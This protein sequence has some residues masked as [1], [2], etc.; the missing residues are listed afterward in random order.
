M[1]EELV[2][3]AARTY[4]GTPWKHQA[5]VKG[6]GVDCIGL[7]V[8]AFREAG[9]SIADVRDYGRCPNPRRFLHHLGAQFDRISGG[10]T[11]S[12][13]PEAWTF[14]RQGDLL[15]FV[16]ADGMPQHVGIA[17]DNG[18]IHTY[19][20]AGFVA[21]HALDGEWRARVHSVWRIK[22]WRRS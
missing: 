13:D 12:A 1:S 20:T 9:Y 21:E 19:Q 8:G 7:L 11:E 4:L 10:D 17:T 16:F 2:I 3:Q 18:V 22:P 6:I 5:R 14:A 15:V